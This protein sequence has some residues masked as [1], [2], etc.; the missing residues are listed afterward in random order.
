MYSEFLSPRYSQEGC[1]ML[2]KCSGGH[3]GTLGEPWGALGAQGACAPPLGPG[4]LF[5]I[6]G[7]N[8]RPRP[9]Q[10]PR[11]TL[12]PVLKLHSCGG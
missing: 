2:G 1:K 7:C 6:P 9:A 10:D 3:W 4:A 8:P 5:P 11:D 12:T